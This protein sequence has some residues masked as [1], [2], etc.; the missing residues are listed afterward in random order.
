MVVSIGIDG[1]DPVVSTG[2]VI[3]V[4]VVIGDVIIVSVVE[5]G[6]ADKSTS[7]PVEFSGVSQPIAAMA[8]KSPKRML[9]IHKLYPFNEGIDS[10]VFIRITLK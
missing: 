3:T 6:G 8:R 1:I 7:V 10:V 5:G 9:F 2:V 4:S